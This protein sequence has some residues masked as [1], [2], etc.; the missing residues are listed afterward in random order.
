MRLPRR[1]IAAAFMF[2][3]VFALA[4]TSA[5]P[6]CVSNSSVHSGQRNHAAETSSEHGIVLQAADLTATVVPVVARGAPSSDTTPDSDSCAT[7]THCNLNP[8]SLESP[9][10]SIELSYTAAEGPGSTWFVHGTSATHA[11]PP[12]KA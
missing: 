9:N 7:T 2:V 10:V 8:A 6:S 4:G 12:P 1:R 5:P 3:V 11:S